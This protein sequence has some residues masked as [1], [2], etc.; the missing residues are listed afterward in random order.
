MHASSLCAAQFV[1]CGFGYL[2][3]MMMTF[4]CI[5]G[6]RGVAAAAG[7]KEEEDDRITGP[8]DRI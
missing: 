3:M 7:S 4:H 2:N 5:T 8:E 1:Y 6:N